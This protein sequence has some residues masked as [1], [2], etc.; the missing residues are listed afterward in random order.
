MTIQET[1]EYTKWLVGHIVGF[2]FWLFV[3]VEVTKWYIVPFVR[4]FL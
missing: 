4:S 1:K 3:G 2:L